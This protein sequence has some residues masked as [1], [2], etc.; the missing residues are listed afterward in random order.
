MTILT[1]WNGRSPDYD[2]WSTKTG[3][4]RAGLNGDII[5]YYPMLDCGLELSSMGIRVDE[6]ALIRQLELRGCP[7]R[8]DL[9]FH[10]RLLNHTLP[11]TI[12]GGIG[13]SCLCMFYLR[14][15]HIGEIQSSIWP[16]EMGEECRKKNIFLL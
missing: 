3:N 12:G 15:A 8:K 16:P 9:Y 13:Q 7:E 14:K 4:T 2:D 10:K 11:Q 1:V 6:E 5:V